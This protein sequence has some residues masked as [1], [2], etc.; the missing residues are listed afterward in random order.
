M[1]LQLL[2]ECKLAHK[3]FRRE[4]FWEQHC[5]PTEKAKIQSSYLWGPES[6]WTP[7]SKSSGKI[8][9]ISLRK[10]IQIFSKIDLV[11]FNIAYKHCKRFFDSLTAGQVGLAFPSPF[12][13]PT[14]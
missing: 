10:K 11:Y 7:A 12:G 14:S 2:R 5:A 13:K 8:S 3:L 6:V 4:K 1:Y 9:Y